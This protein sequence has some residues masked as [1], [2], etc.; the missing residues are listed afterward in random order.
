MLTVNASTWPL[1]LSQALVC[2]I[3]D[4]HRSN[5]H[6]CISTLMSSS[7]C[8][9]LGVLHL[10][11]PA[12]TTP[13]H[14]LQV[15]MIDDS[16]L[17]DPGAPQHQALDAQGCTMVVSFTLLSW[18]SSFSGVGRSFP[19]DATRIQSTPSPCLP[20]QRGWTVPLSDYSAGTLISHRI[21]TPQ[22]NLVRVHGEHRMLLQCSQSSFFLVHFP[23]VTVV[24]RDHDTN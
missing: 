12:E 6:V 10:R 13:Y 7:P 2:D 1:G 21:R 4:H 16:R 20:H 9:T 15:M 19:L 22:V 8:T 23:R 11:L 5:M 17:S 24:R 14:D 18:T 3:H